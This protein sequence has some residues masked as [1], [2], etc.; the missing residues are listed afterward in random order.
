MNLLG[1]GVVSMSDEMRGVKLSSKLLA[2][3][4][5]KSRIWSK[6]R[7]GAVMSYL[8]LVGVILVPFLLQKS[9]LFWFCQ[10]SFQSFELSGVN[11]AFQNYP[12]CGNSYGSIVVAIFGVDMRCRVRLSC[13]NANCDTSNVVN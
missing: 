1:L 7:F 12:C 6:L 8:G 4:P 11:F 9:D 10:F 3:L 5:S 2:W 13:P